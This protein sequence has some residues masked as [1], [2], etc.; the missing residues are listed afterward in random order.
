[1]TGIS[2][3]FSIEALWPQRYMKQKPSG[4]E[5]GIEPGNKLLLVISLP[6][7]TVESM[8]NVNEE[9]VIVEILPGNIVKLR[10]AAKEA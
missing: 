4:T 8:V 1:M 10:F 2:K 7:S 3:V 6:F 9:V 5:H